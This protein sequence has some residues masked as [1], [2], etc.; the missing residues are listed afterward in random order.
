M[1]LSIG[2]GAIVTDAQ[3]RI[4][5][6]NQAALNILGFKRKDL[7]GKWYPETVLAEKLSGGVINNFERPISRAFL[8]GQAVSDR[9]MLRRKDGSRV[10]VSLTISPV[11]SKSKPIGAI[12]V[13]RDITNELLLEQAK[14]D[15]ISISS[16][17]LRTPATAVKQYIGM[18]LEGY[19]GSFSASQRKLLTRAYE[20]NERQ[21][22]IIDDLLR[23]A[24]VDSGKIVLDIETVDIISLTEDVIAEQQAKAIQRRQVID[25]KISI[26]ELAVNIDAHRMRMVLENLLDNAIKYTPEQKKI[27]VAIAR[28][29]NYA[30]VKI[31]DQGVGIDE[32]NIKMVFN[33]FSRIPNP[34]SIEA[35][36]TGLGLY[37]A[38]KIVALHGGSI[39]LRS[40]VGK[41]SI[42]CIRLPIA[43]FFTAKN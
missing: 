17:Q 42:F 16:H 7:V 14:D 4:S 29:S 12:E 36:G 5:N 13:F 2:E 33:K 32:D 10:P 15:F 23:V 18:L 37:W 6:I 31:A 11:L 35:G 21:L 38:D 40:T 39:V 22:Q 24:R 1:F 43:E 34:L 27:T 28:S 26:A 20:S 8:T 3:G 19:Y 30:E 25:L 41:G 9:I